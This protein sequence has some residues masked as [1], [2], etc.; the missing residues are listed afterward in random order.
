MLWLI[1][2]FVQRLMKI[3]AIGIVTLR[4]RLMVWKVVVIVDI[5]VLT[6]SL[7]YLKGFSPKLQKIYWRL[8]GIHGAPHGLTGS[9][10]GHRS[11]APVFKP[12]PVY[13]RRVFHL[14]LRLIE[15]TFYTKVAV[16]QQQHFFGAYTMIE[17]IKSEI[18]CFR[19]EISEE[20]QRWYHDAK[21]L[22]SYIGAEEEM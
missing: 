19:N 11:I 14:S 15:S 8:W 1:Q 16:K 7:D 9:T 10:V 3:V 22:A 17:N 2:M 21:Q 13:V 4:L 18:K 20:F 6:I 12:W 5:T